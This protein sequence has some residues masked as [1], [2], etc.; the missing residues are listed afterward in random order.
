MRISSSDIGCADNAFSISLGDDH[1]DLRLET[2][3]APLGND[4]RALGDLGD[5]GA[6]GDLRA[7]GDLGDLGDLGAATAS[8]TG[9]SIPRRI[10]ILRRVP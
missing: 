9:L 1:G 6:L 7:L 2:A 5:L 4:L 3:T 8:F 10:R